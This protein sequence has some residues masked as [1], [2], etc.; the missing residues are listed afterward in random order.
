MCPHEDQSHIVPF[1]ASDEDTLQP[2]LSYPLAG[3]VGHLYKVFPL[4]FRTVFRDHPEGDRSS[5][6]VPYGKWDIH[7]L[8]VS[9]Y[10]TPTTTTRPDRPSDD[11]LKFNAKTKDM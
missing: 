8:G 3:E 2:P 10:V 4:K 9:S 6:V 1:G 5:E 7:E 11:I